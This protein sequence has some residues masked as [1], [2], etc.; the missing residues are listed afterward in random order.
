MEKTNLRYS[1][2]ELLD[3][4]LIFCTDFNKQPSQRDILNDDRFPT[5][6]TYIARFGSLK[7]AISRAGLCKIKNLS[8]LHDMVKDYLETAG[9]VFEEW[10]KSENVFFDF[11]ITK[12]DGTT[13]IVDIVNTMGYNNIAIVNR[14][15]SY[16]EICSNMRCDKYVVIKDILDLSKLKNIK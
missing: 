14:V 7:E 12:L 10:Y 3:L 11:L 5:H 4:L 2:Q 15:L 8:A 13:V 6:H 1:D 16:R 9:V